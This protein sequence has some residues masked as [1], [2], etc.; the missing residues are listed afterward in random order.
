MPQRVEGVARSIWK[1]S[2]DEVLRLAEDEDVGLVSVVIERQAAVG[3]P[4]D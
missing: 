1:K 3:P 4:G 2:G